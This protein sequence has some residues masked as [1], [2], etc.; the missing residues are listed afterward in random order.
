VPSSNDQQHNLH[1]KEKVD[2][3]ST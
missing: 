3:L 1:E 2:V